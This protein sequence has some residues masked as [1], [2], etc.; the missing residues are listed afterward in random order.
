MHWL[1]TTHAR[2]WQTTRGLD[3]QGAVYQGRFK[4]IPVSTDDHFLR[5]CRYVERNPLRAGL[6]ERAEQ[7]RWSSISQHEKLAACEIPLATWPAPRPSDWVTFVNTPQSDAELN[8][9]RHAIKRAEPFGDDEWKELIKARL[10]LVAR[11]RGRPS[12]PRSA[13][14]EK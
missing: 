12:R 14:L 2:R 6:V 3:G 8:A 10:G 4:A 1:T 7:W 5:V 11:K 9:V 13:V